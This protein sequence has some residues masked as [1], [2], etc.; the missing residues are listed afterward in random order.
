V[1][2]HPLPSLTIVVPTIGRPTL[3]TTLASI[4]RQD[5]HPGDRVIVALDTFE[6]PERPDIVALVASYGFEL[7]PVDGGVHF[8][9][10]P[11]LN[12]AIRTATTEYLCAL[13]DD[14]IYVDGALAR[15]RPQLV[16]GRAGL[17][18]FLS[19]WREIL[20]DAPVLRVSHI[21]GCC[22]FAPVPSLVEVKTEQRIEVDFDWIVDVV[23]RTGQPPI[24]I[25]DCAI[26]ARPEIVNGQPVQALAEYRPRARQ[27]GRPLRVLL[28]HPGASWSTADVYEGLI[29]GLRAHGVTVIPYRLDTR[30]EASTKALHW[31]WRTKKKTDPT[32]EK[33]NTADVM[34]HA[35]VGI[36]EMALREQ[37]DVVLVVSAMLL[38]PDVIKMLKRAGLRVTVLFTESPYDHEHEMRTAALVDGCW[39]NE[40]TVVPEFRKVNPRSGYLPHAWHPL[41]HY[42]SSQVPG[43]VPSHDVVFVGSGF[44]ERVAWFN[45]IDWTGIDLGLYGTWKGLGLNKQVAACV[46]DGPVSNEYASALYRRAHI[47]LNL[48]RRSKGWGRNA[49]PIAHAESLS[50]RAYELAAC[51]SFSLSDYRAEVAEVFGDLVPTFTT[52]TEAAAL[53]RLWLHDADGRARIAQQLPACVAESSWVVRAKTVLGDLARLIHQQAA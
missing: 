24:W 38:H 11:Q 39:T 20:W 19:P 13:G 6:Q 9:G 25:R 32:L 31:L 17:V 52:P 37:P 28:A 48:Y 42:A 8:F 35:G 53:I 12:A 21:S 29:Y 14:D 34:Y 45:A 4:A 36:V 5:L 50:P 40:R 51:G 44:T 33:P 7:L 46:K 3:A 16:D 41:K 15:I 30:I 49:P 23:A 47:G 27:T 2:K 26:L 10:N 1:S 22:L 43:D 18:Q